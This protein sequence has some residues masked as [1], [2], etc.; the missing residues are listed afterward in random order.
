[1]KNSECA[2]CGT[3]ISSGNDSKEHVIPNAIGG[4]KKVSGF[5]CRECNNKSGDNWEVELASQLNPLSLFFSISRDR[6]EVPSQRF[7]TTSGNKVVLNVDGTM[8]LAKPVYSESPH[9]AGVNIKIT[10]RS[11]KEANRMLNGVKRKYPQVNLEEL[12]SLSEKRSIYPSDMINFNLSFGGELAGRSI[13]KSALALVVEAGVSAKEC[14]HAREYLTNQDGEACFGY[15]Y[16]KDLV[17]NRPE[18]IP[19][20][21]VY[22]KGHS[23]SGQILGYVEYFGVQRMV[24]S[25]SSQFTGEDFENI[26]AINPITGA[27]LGLKVDLQLTPNEIQDSYDYKKIPDGAIKEAL[28]QVIP[29]G[30]ELSFQKERDRVLNGAIL[31]AFENCGAKEGQVLTDEHLRKVT[32]LLFEKIEPFLLHQLTI[33]KEVKQYRNCTASLH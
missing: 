26:Y 20:H 24:M 3:E 21:C 2:L 13:V 1:M 11:M 16:E 19:F 31:Y 29:T 7:G 8:D 30:M 6:G 14:E 12:V 23:K 22:V 32:S 10:A 15:F 25:L 33:S 5:I 9:E 17:L 28:A 27:A 18:G 4:R